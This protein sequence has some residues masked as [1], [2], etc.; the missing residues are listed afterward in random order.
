MSATSTTSASTVAVRGCDG[1]TMCCKIMRIDALQK[2]RGV[3]CKHCKPGLGCLIYAN[4]PQ[5][6]S[7]FLC[8]YLTDPR[9]GEDWK[10]SRSKLVL[11]TD[12]GGNRLVAHVDPQR[13]DAWKQEPYY[14]GLKEWAKA[15]AVHGKHVA[16]CIGQRTYFIFPDR[17]VDL[18]IVGDDERVITGE[19]A[20]ASG[21]RLEAH[22]VH[23]DDPRI[24]NLPRQPSLAASKSKP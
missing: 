16:V 4:K 6:C 9:L 22:K 21:V 19:R 20:T 14:S 17:D 11:L 1:C 10:P 23:K 3:W 24:Q 5:E 15:G 18:G 12:A 7:A 2:P 8:G 13:P